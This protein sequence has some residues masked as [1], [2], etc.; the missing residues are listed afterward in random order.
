MSIFNPNPRDNSTGFELK[1]KTLFR[2][3][4]IKYFASIQAEAVICLG[5]K[6]FI[7]A[8]LYFLV[9]FSILHF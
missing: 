3:L 7:K 4:L 5:K 8:Q 9:N 2:R 6:D 1:A